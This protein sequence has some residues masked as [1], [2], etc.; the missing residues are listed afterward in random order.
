MTI[1]FI[2]SHV[3]MPLSLFQYS[4]V[5]YGLLLP[6]ILNL[7]VWNNSFIASLFGGV[8]VFFQLLLWGQ[9][10]FPKRHLLFQICF[11][12]ILF[13]I[14]LMLLG[15]ALYYTVDLSTSSQAFVFLSLP[16]FGILFMLKHQG[17]QG[18]L[19]FDAILQFKKDHLPKFLLIGTYTILVGMLF[20]QLISVRT[21]EALTSPWTLLP[22]TFWV[23]FFFSTL[24]WIIS[25]WKVDH[26]IITFF[27]VGVQLFLAYGIATIVYGIG[28]GFDPFIHQEAQSLIAENGIVLP[29]TP[30]YIGQYALI[31]LLHKL[32]GFSL[33][34]LD[35]LLVPLLAAF[36]IPLFLSEWS[37]R[38]KKE[39]LLTKKSIWLSFVY[40]CIP[41]AF[42]INTTPQGLATVL[43]LFI[44]IGS[45]AL[46]TYRTDTIPLWLLWAL[47]LASVVTHPLVGI[48]SLIFLTLLTHELY[49]TRIHHSVWVH[50]FILFCSILIGSIALPI[51]FF[52][53]G[54]IST[55]LG[56]LIKPLSQI[57]F[58]DLL[59]WFPL[60][61]FLSEN[62]YRS[63]FFEFGYF[64]QENIWWMLS[65]I[66]L[67]M[68]YWLT[69]RSRYSYLRVYGLSAIIFLLNAIILS[70]FIEFPGLIQYENQAYAS[71]LF[72][73]AFLTASPL[74]LLAGIWLY[75]RIENKPYQLFFYA[76]CFAWLVT[77]VLFASYPRNNRYE[78]GRQYS[79]SA[80][81]IATVKK[82]GEKKM[83]FVVLA[84]QSVS[85]A[86][87]KEFGFQSYFL[88]PENE[89]LF[90]Y[91]IPTS[92]PLYDN[93]LEM[94][95]NTPS[96]ENAMKAVELTGV[97]TVFFVLNDY[98]D[99]AIQVKEQAKL[100]ADEWIDIDGGKNTIFTYRF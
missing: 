51:V 5:S 40:L 74:L 56:A 1:H 35:K 31:V 89:Q 57:Q 9:Q 13:I 33:L 66:I 36:G 83:N 86:A 30:Y 16:V 23:L 87:I 54:K 68:V 72:H 81:D 94:V 47:G 65:L 34:W 76:F 20:Y 22:S 78:L 70:V 55:Q 3:Y 99:N 29:K 41:F 63:F 7:F 82:I 15:S 38:T 77:G 21:T 50:R 96:R 90:Y 53:N 67:L 91:P 11:A 69:V 73:T 48:P 93:Y 79:V 60:R 75:K 19:P 6:V 39:S 12:G 62:Q 64:I 27:L 100:E 46:L 59:T 18:Q 71:R 88:T 61:V 97:D 85:A 52:I 24:I 44:I 32:F 84:N 4:I 92:S 8:F 80:T 58:S 43:F 25:L 45:F 2:A 10:L 14:A 49:R 42:F 26:K 95:Y 17:M 98:W 28:Y 37:F